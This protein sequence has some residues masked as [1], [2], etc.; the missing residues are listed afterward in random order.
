MAIWSEFKFPILVSGPAI[1]GMLLYG[2]LGKSKT[3]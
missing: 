2:K 1:L 3:K